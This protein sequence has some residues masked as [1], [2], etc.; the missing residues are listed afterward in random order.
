MSTFL[1]QHKHHNKLQITVL[2]YYIFICIDA[3]VLWS[4]DPEHVF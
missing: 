4:I 1:I 2:V 3:L